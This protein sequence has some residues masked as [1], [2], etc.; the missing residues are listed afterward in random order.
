MRRGDVQMKH[1]VLALAVLAAAP[2]AVYATAAPAK[3]AQAG[4]TA[5]IEL[6]EFSFKGP[7]SL[8]AGQTKLTFRNRGQFPHNFTVTTALGGGKAF[9]SKTL[10]KGKRQ[11]LNVNLKPGAYVAVCT[12]FNG[13]HLAQ[14]MVKRFT[15]GKFDQSTGTWG[16]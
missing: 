3:T 8:P 9:K 16:Q 7:A 15:V 2:A 4:G 11:V 6:R 10:E 14:G 1:R 5:T 13:G 12:I